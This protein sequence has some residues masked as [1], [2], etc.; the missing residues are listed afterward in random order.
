MTQSAGKHAAPQADA[1]RAYY[2]EIPEPREIHAACVMSRN[3][4]AS[5]SLSKSALIWLCAL[6]GHAGLSENPLRQGLPMPE[7]GVFI[8][9]SL[10][11][12]VVADQFGP[13][14]LVYLK[15]SLKTVMSRQ[16][17]NNTAVV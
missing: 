14:M 2:V 1:A 12:S 13:A 6:C 4:P 15:T 5:F 11:L 10:R 9:R 17:F 3:Q 16:I 8:V 7:Q